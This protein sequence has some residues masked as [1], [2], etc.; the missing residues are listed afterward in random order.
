MSH[1]TAPVFDTSTNYRRPRT[2]KSFQIFDALDHARFDHVRRL[3]AT[4]PACLQ[5]TKRVSADVPP[6][7][8]VDYA[9]SNCRTWNALLEHCRRTGIA[10]PHAEDLTFP[11][12][13]ASMKS[14]IVW[15]LAQPSVA[16][17]VLAPLHTAVLCELT[18][19]FHILLQRA[20]H[21]A[22]SV[23]A[24]GKTPLHL[25]CALAVYTSSDSAL[26][27]V[28]LLHA[29]AADFNARDAD[30]KTPLHNLVAALSHSQP[31]YGLVRRRRAGNTLAAVVPL[32]DELLACGA[33]IHYH[34]LDGASVMEHALHSGLDYLVIA[35]R[36]SILRHRMCAS[37]SALKWRHRPA[38]V[39]GIWSCLSEELVCK[40]FLH[41]SPKHVATG[42]GATCSA[43]R[44]IALS[45]PLWRHLDT[46]R[47][48]FKLRA[49]L[50]CSAQLTPASFPQL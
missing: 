27:F 30:G 40:I 15:L 2:E 34:D 24:R 35:Q 14:I 29:S 26:R 11:R 7:S 4:N 38:H 1:R 48:L 9:L 31:A 50:R 12:R 41:L 46:S 19:A 42:I 37:P 21:L 44:K 13:L 10:L 33:D 43:L 16:L 39:T 25:V 6:Q 28:R 32:L 49:R 17:P 18:D 23:D 8:V 3:A 45:E 47:C 5:A 22:R 20:P 36:A